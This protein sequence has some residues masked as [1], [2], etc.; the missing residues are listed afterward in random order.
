MCSLLVSF[1]TI[2]H[3]SVSE[4]TS[5]KTSCRMKTGDLTTSNTRCVMTTTKATKQLTMLT[6][7]LTKVFFRHGIF[8]LN[9]G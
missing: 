4:R 9:N 6:L 2:L 5:V 1:V 8:D 7:S 3:N